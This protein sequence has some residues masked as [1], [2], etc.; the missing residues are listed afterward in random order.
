MVLTDYVNKGDQVRVE[1][2]KK[3]ET[4]VASEI[5]VTKRAG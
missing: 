4:I 3:G 2:R 5:T 1:Y